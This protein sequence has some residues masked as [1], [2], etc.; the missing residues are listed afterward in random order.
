[1]VPV[2]AFTARVVELWVWFVFPVSSAGLFTGT[3]VKAVAALLSTSVSS[4][5]GSHPPR[6]VTTTSSNEQ[7]DASLENLF[8]RSSSWGECGVIEQEPFHPTGDT[9]APVCAAE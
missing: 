3:L 6:P 4:G 5:A 7:P 2:V 9:N 1:M 8:I